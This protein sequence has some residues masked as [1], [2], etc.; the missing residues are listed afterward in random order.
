LGSPSGAGF[1]A[2]SPTGA[3]RT[4]PPAALA[5]A[6]VVREGSGSGAR[7]PTWPLPRVIPEGS[8]ISDQDAG[9]LL[10]DFFK[11]V[12][13]K[14]KTASDELGEQQQQQQQPASPDETGKG[15]MHPLMASKR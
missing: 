9:G 11:S 1:A 10:I 13:D 14:V 5:A 15:A 8:E 3:P 4:L 2:P 12:H 6:A 7:S